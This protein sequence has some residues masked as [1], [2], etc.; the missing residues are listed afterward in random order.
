MTWSHRC[1]L[2]PSFAHKKIVSCAKCNAHLSGLEPRGTFTE[3]VSP[4]RR[5]WRSNRDVRSGLA[6][7]NSMHSSISFNHFSEKGV[8]HGTITHCTLSRVGFFK[9]IFA[10]FDLSVQPQTNQK[11]GLIE[12]T[13]PRHVE[14]SGRSRSLF[15]NTLVASLFPCTGPGCQP[16]SHQQGKAGRA[17]RSRLDNLLSTRLAGTLPHSHKC[18]GKGLRGVCV[19]EQADI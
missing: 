4:E 16:S 2:L 10:A 19:W 11:L 5:P 17:E 8:F 18:Q 6:F 3:V 9:V 14:H 12:C 1:L 13:Y 7:S 15:Q